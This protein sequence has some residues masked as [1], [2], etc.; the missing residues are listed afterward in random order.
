MKRIIAATAL[1]LACAPAI[2]AKAQAVLDLSLI[3]CQQ[4]W[5]R[6]PSVRH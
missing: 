4:F 6:T 5:R 2:P 3:T 1:V